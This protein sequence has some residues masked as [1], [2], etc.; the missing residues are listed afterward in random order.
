[1]EKNYY[2][3][4]DGV[5]ASLVNKANTNNTMRSSDVAPPV[6]Q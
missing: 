5:V 1:M 6:G 4:D 3:D 2:D